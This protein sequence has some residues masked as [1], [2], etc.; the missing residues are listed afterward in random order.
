MKKLNRPYFVRAY[1]RWWIGWEKMLQ[2]DGWLINC[3]TIALF[4]PADWIWGVKKN[5]RAKLHLRAMR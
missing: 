5:V 3:L 1:G 4:I 2:R